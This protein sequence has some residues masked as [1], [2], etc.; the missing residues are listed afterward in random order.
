MYPLQEP[1]SWNTLIRS[2]PTDIKYRGG[3]SCP[4]KA[5]MAGPTNMV[6]VFKH[7]QRGYRVSE[8]GKEM[9]PS[10]N[11]APNVHERCIVAVGR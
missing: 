1:G 2:S 9:D 8:M 4:G 11:Q 7:M 5:N 10:P 6:L 3:N